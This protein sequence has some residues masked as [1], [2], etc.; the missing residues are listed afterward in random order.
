M[1]DTTLKTAIGEASA[2]PLENLVN[3]TKKER[4]PRTRKPKDGPKT[5]PEAKRVMTSDEAARIYK[6]DMAAKRVQRLDSLTE[7]QK[8]D[9]KTTQSDVRIIVNKLMGPSKLIGALQD[10]KDE[11]A[12]L[13]LVC[14]NQ[15]HIEAVLNVKTFCEFV[16]PAWYKAKWEKEPDYAMQVKKAYAL[17]LEIFTNPAKE[18]LFLEYLGNRKPV[19]KKQK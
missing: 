6:F 14:K 5:E 19:A 1:T 11:L 16:A 13:N 15:K 9:I 4:K 2:N 3:A 8:S 18:R 7:K 12:M 10:S 17:I